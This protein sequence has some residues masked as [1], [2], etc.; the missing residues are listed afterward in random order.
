MTAAEPHVVSGAILALRLY[1]VAYA[2]DLAAVERLGAARAEETVG[3]LRLTRV[4][5]K[6]IALPDPPVEIGLGPVDLHVGGRR[7]AAEAVARVYD[8]GVVSI[9]IRH[10]VVNL[11]WD[12]FVD[13]TVELAGAAAD[14]S[15]RVWRELVERVCGWASPAFERASSSGLSEEYLVSIVERFARPIDTDTLLQGDDVVRLLTGESK[16]LSPAARRDLLKYM[17]SYYSD[18][19][20]VLTWD[21]A[22]LIQP[23]FDQDVADV[24]EVATA[25]LLELR[26]YD[27]LL[28]RELPRMYDRVQAAHRRL[29]LLARGRYSRLAHELHVLVAEVTEITERIDNALKVTED[30]YLA[31]IYGAA[32]ELF[33][34]PSW[35]GAVDRKLDI[36][37][38]T[39][40]ALHDEANAAR[41]ELLELGILLLIVLEIVLAWLL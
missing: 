26:Y 13:R 37:R 41:A 30:V 16:P 4:E 22:F 31:R 2:I 24:L 33:R 9:T 17:F 7:L 3:R 8:F 40:T 35:A 6:A 20:V 32:L 5:A 12:A 10:P 39:Y 25:Q 11:S 19:V 21:Q 18:D 1:D 28:D 36:I 14:G 38:Q 29:A 15:D 23:E 27:A 34:V